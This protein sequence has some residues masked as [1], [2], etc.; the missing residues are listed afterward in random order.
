MLGPC[1]R[2]HIFGALGEQVTLG[3]KVLVVGAGDDYDM[4]HGTAEAWLSRDFDELTTFDGSPRTIDMHGAGRLTFLNVEDKVLCKLYG[5]ELAR[6]GGPDIVVFVDDD[7]G[8]EAPYYDEWILPAVLE[9][10]NS[11]VWVLNV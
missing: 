3:K 11:E 2:E 6:D 10:E 7:E 1:D 4:M 8:D 5:H 9:N